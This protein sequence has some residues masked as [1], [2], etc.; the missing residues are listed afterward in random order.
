MRLRCP[1]TSGRREL[2]FNGHCQVNSQDSGSTH[3]DQLPHK[4]A[5]I[6]SEGAIHLG[7]D[8]GTTASPTQAM[9]RE[10]KHETSAKAARR[11]AGYV[12]FELE[13]T[14]VTTYMILGIENDVL[15]RGTW[16]FPHRGQ[17][18]YGKQTK[19]MAMD[20]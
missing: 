9:T 16:I 8:D 1:F 7:A 2:P 20:R 4:G 3:P 15:L 14:F 13:I 6:S 5:M 12:S 11:K 10:G 17:R 19:N 18:K